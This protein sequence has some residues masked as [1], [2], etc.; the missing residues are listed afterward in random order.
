MTSGLPTKKKLERNLFMRQEND[1]MITLQLQE[2]LK[3]FGFQVTNCEV[4]GEAFDTLVNMLPGGFNRSYYGI[5]EMN[6]SEMIYRA[7]ALE[8]FNGEAEKYNCETFSIEKGEYLA[9]TLRDWRKKTSSIK[10]IFHNMFQ[11]PLAHR[12]K[13]C[14]EWYK[15]DD[16]MVCMIKIRSINGSAVSK[17]RL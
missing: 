1:T 13:V 10:D 14:V 16:E 2:D 3:V 15:N 17:A 6:G 5:S 11:N 12:A 4:I 9:V 7:T 8:N